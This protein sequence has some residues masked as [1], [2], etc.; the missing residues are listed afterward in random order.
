M[1]RLRKGFTPHQFWTKSKT[2]A[3]FTLIELLVVIAIIGLLATISVLMLNNARAKSRDAKRLSDVQVV[4]AGLEQ[5]WIEKAAYPSADPA[6]NLGT[7]TYQVLGSNGF[8]A[9]PGTGT[10]YLQKIPA[11]PNANEY[12]LYAS[13]ISTGYAI[14]FTTELVTTYGNPGTYY[15]HSGSVD[16]DSS[17]K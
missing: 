6:V 1:S 7:G 5:H 10:V 11:G 13:T 2:G 17:S 4:R 12:Y 16:T 14:R 9:S 8:E 15:A 3:G